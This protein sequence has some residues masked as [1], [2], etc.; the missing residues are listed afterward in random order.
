MGGHANGEKTEAGDL[1]CCSAS[2]LAYTLGQRLVEM[3][4]DRKCHGL[5][6]K[7]ESGDALI[8]A[9]PRNRY[10]DEVRSAFET[11]MAGYKLLEA[12]YP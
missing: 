9:T 3:Q 11:V 5:V 7:L 6:M 8:A 12:R 10:Q 2:I 4:H 1:V